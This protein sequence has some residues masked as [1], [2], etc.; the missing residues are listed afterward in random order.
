MSD[1]AKYNLHLEQQRILDK[2]ILE[3]VAQILLRS[4]LMK[5]NWSANKKGG[6]GLV[7]DGKCL[8]RTHLDDKLLGKFWY[9]ENL[10]IKNA[11]AKAL[12][13]KVVFAD[14]TF[15]IGGPAL[16]EEIKLK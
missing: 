7:V 12:G 5:V 1:E 11:V 4:G 13:D 3:E 14:Y 16:G 10:D 15:D 8:I 9:R 2:P 6:I